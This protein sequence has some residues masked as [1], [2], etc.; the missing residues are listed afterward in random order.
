[1][2]STSSLPR[3]RWGASRPKSTDEAAQVLVESGVVA[4]ADAIVTRNVRDRARGELKFPALRV[5]TPQQCLEAFPC[6]R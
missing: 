5:L 1:M 6:L 4:Q 3:K 2:V